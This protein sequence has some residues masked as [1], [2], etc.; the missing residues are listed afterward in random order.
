MDQVRHIAMLAE[1]H[2]DHRLTNIVYMGM[3]EPLLN[4]RNVR[5]RSTASPAHP[6]WA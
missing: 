1:R 6:A 2:H 3:G 4:Y 5:N